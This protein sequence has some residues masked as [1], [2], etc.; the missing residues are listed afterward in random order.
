MKTVAQMEASPEFKALSYDQQLEARAQYAREFFPKNREF[1]QLPDDQKAMALEQFIFRPPSLEDSELQKEVNNVWARAKAGDKQILEN[2]KKEVIFNAFEKQSTVAAIFDHFLVTPITNAVQGRGTDTEAFI[3]HRQIINANEGTSVDGHKIVDFYNTILDRDEQESKHLKAYQTIAGI[4]GFATDIG[5]LWG[6]G[7]GASA[8]KARGLGKLATFAQNSM[9][10][11]ATTPGAEFLAHLVGETVH[12]GVT[13]TIGV[14]REFALGALNDELP[15]NPDFQTIA[16][17]AGKWFGEYFVGDLVVNYAT[18]IVFPMSKMFLKH[19]YKG[20]G[21]V[22]KMYKALNVPEYKKMQEYIFSGKSIPGD[23][24]ARAPKEIQKEL[25]STGAA[26]KLLKNVEAL[27][28]MGAAIVIANKSGFNMVPAAEG[29]FEISPKVPTKTLKPAL[30]STPKEVNE[31]IMQGMTKNGIPK[32]FAKE[33]VE[34]SPEESVKRV[35]GAVQ[36]QEV[37][38]S[39]VIEGVLP[40]SANRRV[41]VLAKV[42]APVDGKF[43]KAKVNTF[44]RAFARGA[45]AS[46]EAAK[47]L[48]VVEGKDS[49]KLLHNRKVV[50]SISTEA[51]KRGQE[52][53]AVKKLMDV[54]VDKLDL[55]SKGVKLQEKIGTGYMENLVKQGVF[56]PEYAHH[57]ADLVLGEALSYSKGS[58]YLFPKLNPGG[59]KKFATFQEAA[60][61]IFARTLTRDAVQSTAMQNGMKLIEKDSKYI[62]KQGKQV[63]A[64]GPDLKTI[65]DLVPE[66]A[67]KFGSELGP[68]FTLRTAGGDLAIRYTKENV[69]VGSQEKLLQF[70]DKF[71]KKGSP[72]S[73]SLGGGNVGRLSFDKGKKIFEVEIPDIGERRVFKDVRK[74]RKY[75]NSGWREMDELKYTALKKGYRLEYRSGKW[76]VYSSD[77]LSSVYDTSEELAKGLK[78]VPMPEWAPELTDI[79]PELTESFERA[80]GNFFQLDNSELYEDAAAVMMEEEGKTALRG[81]DD[82]KVS[83]LVGQIFKPIKTT[84]EDFVKDGADPEVLHMFNKV[85]DSRQILEGLKGQFRKLAL[86]VFDDGSGKIS[87]KKTRLWVGKYLEASGEEAKRKVIEE[88]KKVNVFLDKGPE[89]EMI[90]KLRALYGENAQ[91]GAMFYFGVDPEKFI[92][93]YLPRIKKFYRENPRKFFTDG[94]TDVFL[95]EVFENKVPGKVDAFFKHSRVTEVLDVALEDDPLAQVYR[96]INTG[97]KEKYFGNILEQAKRMPSL[98]KDSVVRKRFFTY[99]SQI[100]QLPDGDAQQILRKIT[101]RVLN[102]LHLDPKLTNDITSWMMSLGYSASMGFRPW[103]AVRNM[104]QV[105]TTL[106]MRL[107]GNSWVKGA[108]GKVSGKGGEEVFDILRKKGLILSSLPLYGSEVIDEASLLGKMTHKSLQMYKNSDDWTRAIA[109]T[110]AGDKFTAALEKFRK[111]LVDVDGFLHLSGVSQMEPVTKGKIVALLNAGKTASAKDLFAT[112]MVTETMF[113]YRAGMSP[114]LF[115]GTVG[116]MFGMMGH[117][118]VFY[119]D[120]IRRALKYMTPGEKALAGSIFVSNSMAL[121]AAFTSIGVK[122]NNFLPWQ[123]AVFTGGPAWNTMQ[124]TLNLFKGGGDALEARK[125]LFGIGSYHGQLTFEPRKSTLFKWGIPGGYELQKMY[126]GVQMMNEGN[127]WG[128]FLSL[129]GASY[130]PSWMEEF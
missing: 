9:K 66:T 12:A 74:A 42:I 51:F 78:K 25:I 22:D 103:L 94:K 23:L 115:K 127:S 83:T 45:G 15:N 121:Y 5:L 119:V 13:A 7:A 33:V 11:S 63:I 57:V 59:F 67:P 76:I 91:E 10:A 113:P 105:F 20:Y 52:V 87:K 112:Q 31:Y 14:A 75:I 79:P 100:G 55:G 96:Y 41:D 43:T 85:E 47:K 37:K 28:D 116:K 19:G 114:L 38:L 62:L 18:G 21:D 2:M 24:L 101:P 126:D 32:K 130:N 82:Y 117:Y 129:T 49:L 70:M 72:Q 97:L 26:F 102:F 123:P 30:V 60:D 86:S 46:E 89:Q 125:K 4:A 53:D 40:T 98:Q 27:D 93:D 108:I 107:H 92:Q 81:A 88:A 61:D 69:A 95:R 84:L 17:K 118:S 34:I 111:N 54:I 48:S 29:F 39:Q 65:V 35:I 71:T 68:S 56:T 73:V 109:Y 90:Q 44:A 50:A 80:P 120:N 64:E 6:L 99:L 1:V 110:A 8:S 58:W 77:G 104:N 124:D 128:A 106:A 36:A 122:A 16:K 3:E